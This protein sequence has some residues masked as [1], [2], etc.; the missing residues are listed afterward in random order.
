[1]SKARQECLQAFNRGDCSAAVSIVQAAIREQPDDSD[2]RWL[3][4]QFLCVQR[5]WTRA[6]R[7]LTQIISGPQSFTLLPSASVA[8]EMIGGEVKREQVWREGRP[9]EFLGDISEMERLTLLAWTYFREGKGEE[10]QATLAQRDES[11]APPIC[12]WQGQ[13][14]SGFMDLDSPTA[15]FLEVILHEGGYCWVPWCEIRTLKVHKFVRPLDCLWAPCLLTLR[16]GREYQCCASAL[17]PVRGSEDE[18]QRMGRATQ[19]VDD[20]FGGL[21][22]AGAKVFLLGDEQELTIHEV[23]MLEIVPEGNS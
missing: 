21:L 17:Y 15:H 20:G 11:I 19:W 12:E 3:Y 6:D 23:G 2:L 8:R 7:V 9:P 5:D 10:Y 13:R 1:M 4:A 22:G 18:S 14:Y 16:S